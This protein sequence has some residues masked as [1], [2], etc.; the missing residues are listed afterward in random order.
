MTEGEPIM[1]SLMVTTV[2]KA[3]LLV[4]LAL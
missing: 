2:T 1:T 4:L 3:C